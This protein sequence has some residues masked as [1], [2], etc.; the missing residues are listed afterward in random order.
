MRAMSPVTVDYP[1]SLSNDTMPLTSSAGIGRPLSPPESQM[2]Y[3]QMQQ[4]QQQQQQR[5][6]AV[7]DPYSNQPV[8]FSMMDI[9]QQQA[10]YASPTSPT[11]IGRHDI[12]M[13]G[14]NS[15]SISRINT[16]SPQSRRYGDDE[17]DYM[18]YEQTRSPHKIRRPS[19]ERSNDM[20][21]LNMQSSHQL[22]QHQQQQ[23]QQQQSGQPGEQMVRDWLWQSP[24]RRNT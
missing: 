7:E 3:Q 22:Q 12:P 4:Q 19:W 5:N 1:H 17:I 9:K 21:E 15:G 6:L 13:R 8:M 23:Q 24:D 10:R 16:S 18:E 20:N 14:M 2:S 11:N